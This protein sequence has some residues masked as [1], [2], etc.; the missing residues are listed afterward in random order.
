MKK[1]IYANF[2][3]SNNLKEK[4]VCCFIVGLSRCCMSVGE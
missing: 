4:A 1:K 2:A 3:R